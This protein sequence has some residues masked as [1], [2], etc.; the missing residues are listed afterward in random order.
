VLVR[1]PATAH[2]HCLPASA[3]EHTS[4]ASVTTQAENSSARRISGLDNIWLND[5]QSLKG[6]SGYDVGELRDG[7]VLR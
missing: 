4:Q 6:D 2:R 1:S 7:D 3:Q 5:Q